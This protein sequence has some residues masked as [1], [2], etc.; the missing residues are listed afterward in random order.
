MI[1]EGDMVRIRGS[2]AT[3]WRVV[4][5]GRDCAVI[6][7]DRTRIVVCVDDLV[8]AAATGRDTAKL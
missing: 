6:K 2:E 1:R 3:L 7:F 4:H 8:R 5:I